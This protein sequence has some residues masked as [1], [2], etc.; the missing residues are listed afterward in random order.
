MTVH[1]NRIFFHS[2][3]NYQITHDP[4]TQCPKIQESAAPPAPSGSQGV[5]DGVT[6]VIRVFVMNGREIRALQMGLLH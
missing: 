4:L 1:A 6:F 2:S 5:F 3:I